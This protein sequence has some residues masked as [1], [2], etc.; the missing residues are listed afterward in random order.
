[1]TLLAVVA[2]PSPKSLHH[3]PNHLPMS[4]PKH[5]IALYFGRDIDL[6]AYRF[7][8]ETVSD[9]RVVLRARELRGAVRELEAARADLVVIDAHLLHELP[10]GWLE[11]ARSQ[12]AC[13]VAVASAEGDVPSAATSVGV[14]TEAWQLTYLLEGRDWSERTTA[15]PPEQAPGPGITAREREV[16]RLIA[17]G[18]TVRD[19]ARH[20]GLAESTV[21][22]HKSR[23]MRKLGVHKSVELVRL[24]VRL[25]LVDV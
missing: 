1:M 18:A 6:D 25:G 12:L 11:Q 21:D 3:P 20:L 17:T 14:L 2:P 24:A 13:Q 5:R 19:I 8:V 10:A 23:L 22:S 15:E 7:L 16:W 4:R 9:A